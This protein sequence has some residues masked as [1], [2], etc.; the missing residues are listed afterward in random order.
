[1]PLVSLAMLKCLCA[2]IS[3]GALH[4]TSQ[5]FNHVISV[6]HMCHVVTCDCATWKMKYYVYTQLLKFEQPP[7]SRLGL[8][9]KSH[10]ATPL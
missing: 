6:V 3:R 8:L 9:M 1:V 4:D 5:N 2:S 10:F 7:A